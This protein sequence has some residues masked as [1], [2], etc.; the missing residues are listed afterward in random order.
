MIERENQKTTTLIQAIFYLI[1]FFPV[2]WI[3]NYL[4]GKKYNID[5]RFIVYKNNIAR[6]LN[7]N[8][9]KNRNAKFNNFIIE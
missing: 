6:K 5:F 4:Y 8:V 9:Y 7:L 2:N 1:L 3:W